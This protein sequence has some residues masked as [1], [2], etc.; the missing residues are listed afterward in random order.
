MPREFLVYLQDERAD[1][2]DYPFLPELARYEWASDE[3]S[4][5]TREI[6]L[7]GVDPTGD[8]LAGVPVFNEIM[9]PMSFV[10]PVHTL[11]PG[12]IP[13]TAPPTPTYLLVYRNK[14]EQVRFLEMN[15][16]SARL[17]Q[18]LRTAAATTG[19]QALERIAAELAH[20]RPATVVAGGIE[21]LNRMR[22]KDVVLGTRA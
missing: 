20:P 12:R 11:A 2:G 13:A 16:V 6:D 19:R 17:V 9:L 22:D 15:P 14:R 5:D 21:T 4:I 7:Y 18:L 1:A 10:W 8:L 3:L